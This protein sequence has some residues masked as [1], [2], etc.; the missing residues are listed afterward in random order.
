MGITREQLVAILMALLMDRYAAQVSPSPTMSEY[1]S[2]ALEI[3]QAAENAVAKENPILF[4]PP[5]E[6]KNRKRGI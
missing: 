4:R 1:A 5:K 2:A 6:R 3:V